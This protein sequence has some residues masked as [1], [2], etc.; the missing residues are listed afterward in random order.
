MSKDYFQKNTKPHKAP[1]SIL[2]DV[3]H[4]Y[5]KVDILRNECRIFEGLIKVFIFRNK[6]L[7][8]YCT[9]FRPG[10]KRSRSFSRAFPCSVA[11]LSTRLSPPPSPLPTTLYKVSSLFCGQH[12]GRNQ[13]SEVHKLSDAHVSKS[14]VY[15]RKY[16]VLL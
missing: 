14:S 2:S 5:E 3:V 1:Y 6:Y 9:M 8:A 7:A 10:V 15:P 12:E 16:R 13:R 4:S 11:S